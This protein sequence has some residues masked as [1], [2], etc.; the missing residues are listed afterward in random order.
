MNNEDNKDWTFTL[1]LTHLL[2]I[3]TYFTLTLIWEL[4]P[5]TQFW[6]FKLR[7]FVSQNLPSILLKRS[8]KCKMRDVWFDSNLSI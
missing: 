7:F 5:I 2:H 8:E 4:H 1:I 3:F 6:N